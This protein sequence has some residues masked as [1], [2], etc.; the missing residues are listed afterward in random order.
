MTWERLD[1]R[2]EEETIEQIVKEC[3]QSGG[4]YNNATY[5]AFCE[6]LGALSFRGERLYCRLTGTEH[7]SL[8]YPKSERD[9]NTWLR[10]STHFLSADLPERKPCLVDKETG[11]AVFYEASINQIFAYRGLGKSVVANALTGIL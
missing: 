6:R 5:D 2:T 7:T 9:R 3:I 11:G 10:D 1:T 4:I 8:P